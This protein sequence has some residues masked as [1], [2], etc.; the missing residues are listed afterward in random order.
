M[1]LSLPVFQEL[2]GLIHDLC[3]LA[4]PDDKL[5]LVEQRLQPL[6]ASS[7][8]GS[9]E[10]FASRLRGR[11]GQQLREPV[12][13]AITTSETSFFRDGHPFETFRDHLLPFLVERVLESRKRGLAARAIPR[14]GS[15]APP[16]RR[17]RNR[18]AWR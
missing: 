2:R 16:P 15:G 13:E 1:Q 10:A 6:A 8:C 11:E 14:A 12:I 5:Y 4:L 3:G 17:G 18:T 9:F 7:G